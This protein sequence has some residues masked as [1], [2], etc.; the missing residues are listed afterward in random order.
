MRHRTCT[1]D[2]C[3]K[4]HRARGWCSSHYS[5]WLLTGEVTTLKRGS[6]CS[7]PG[8]SEPVICYQHCR[9]HV[10]QH[11]GVTTTSSGCH[12]WNGRLTASGYGVLGDAHKTRAHRLAW[13]I[14]N[15]TSVPEGLVIRHSCDNPPCCNPD[16]LDVGTDADNARDAIQRG[17]RRVINRDLPNAV[18]ECV[19]GHDLTAP[20]SVYVATA[21]GRVR[22]WCKACRSEWNRAYLARKASA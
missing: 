12:M 9:Q 10:I 18:S 15:G 22:S 19:N 4:K 17:R 3:S 2:G 16:H 7:E 8:C 20:G 5:Q 11:V 6:E 13:E 14:A 21:G 1:F